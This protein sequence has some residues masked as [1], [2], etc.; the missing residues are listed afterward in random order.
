MVTLTAVMLVRIWQLQAI[1]QDGAALQVSSCFL[2]SY[3]QIPTASINDF[4]FAGSSSS[5][6]NTAE[7]ENGMRQ[8]RVVSLRKR[9]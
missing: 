4:K 5:N 2:H 8:A 1:Q 3:C 7:R 9:E 6:G